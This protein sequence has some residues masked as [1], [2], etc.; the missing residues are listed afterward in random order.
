MA[1][2]RTEL[3]AART[4]LEK[5]LEQQKK[6][7]E[8]HFAQSMA[9]AEEQHIQHSNA[10]MAILRSSLEEEKQLQVAVAVNS[11]NK[12]NAE[13]ESLKFARD[14]DLRDA[15]QKQHAELTAAYEAGSKLELERQ[16][17][18]LQTTAA[19]N[20][21]DK[22]S[23]ANQAHAAELKSALLAQ[24]QE[25]SSYYETDV[26][27]KLKDQQDN[28]E[29]AAQRKLKEQVDA[30][31]E[32][33][34]EELAIALG[35][36]KQELNTASEADFRNRLKDQ[37]QSLQAIAASS[38]ED[39]MNRLRDAHKEE[40]HM[41]LAKQKQELDLAYEAESC[42]RFERQQQSMQEDA[43]QYLELK[44]KEQRQDFHVSLAEQRE[45]LDGQHAQD[46]KAALEEQ[47]AR[48]ALQA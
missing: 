1:R 4:H 11:A 9:S 21:E 8:E 37:Q 7:H 24:R 48:S 22:L 2:Q 30:L 45:Q 42:A 26:S 38:L 28:I 41:M 47:Q 35:R 14:E 44:L 5:S 29:M 13:L 39:Q 40:L 43:A 34:I 46:K 19:K 16:H 3:E 20:L 18:H 31:K 12:A 27:L 6:A 33:H 25:L 17:Q 32:S 36:Q 15:L 10:A 23:F